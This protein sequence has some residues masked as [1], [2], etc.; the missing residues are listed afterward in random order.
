MRGVV[1]ASELEA[2]RA[3]GAENL[4]KTGRDG[5]ERAAL[6]L[7]LRTAEGAAYMLTRTRVGLHNNVILPAL[8][9]A[10]H[11]L[12]YPAAALVHSH[13]YC[14]CHAGEL[15]SG[16]RDP[17]THRVTKLG[18]AAVPGLGHIRRIYAVTPSGSILLYDGQGEIC[19]PQAHL[20]GYVMDAQGNRLCMTRRG[21]SRFGIFPKGY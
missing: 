1:Y 8:G 2:V 20:K 6:V 10:V 13:P 3:W 16:N 21:S 18:D 14:S 17:V 7:P 9:L 12:R 19:A 11:S 15:F 4:P 5:L